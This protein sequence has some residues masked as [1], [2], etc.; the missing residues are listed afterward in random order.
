VA[1]QG[2]VPIIIEGKVIGA[3]GVSGETPAQDE[4]IAI[5]GA[6]VAALFTKP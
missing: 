6:A 1:L 2:G 5:A 3:I 4:E